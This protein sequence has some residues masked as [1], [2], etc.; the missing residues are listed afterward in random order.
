VTLTCGTAGLARWALC[1]RRGIEASLARLSSL[2]GVQ[3]IRSLRGDVDAPTLSKLTCAPTKAQRAFS[4]AL[5]EATHITIASDDSVDPFVRISVK[6][7]ASTGASDWLHALPGAD[8]NGLLTD[9]Q[10][11]VC[12]AL[13]FGLPCKQGH[14]PCHHLR[15]YL[16]SNFQ[17]R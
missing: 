6:V 1:T 2:P 10:Y 14:W 4:R 15:P 5:A 7:C 8:G 12:F 3:L 13:F 11:A 16:R 9:A 17:S